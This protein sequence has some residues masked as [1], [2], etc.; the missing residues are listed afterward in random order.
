MNSLYLRGEEGCYLST[1]DIVVRVDRSGRGLYVALEPI[2]G[3][4]G[5]FRLLT[6]SFDNLNVFRQLI[7]SMKAFGL[8]EPG[9]TRASQEQFKEYYD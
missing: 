9:H 8:I 4:N 2:A 5:H 1:C 7:T 3:R 6:A